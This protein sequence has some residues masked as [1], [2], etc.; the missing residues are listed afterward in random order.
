MLM[1]R[2]FPAL[3]APLNSMM[4]GLSALSKERLSSK[5]LSWAALASSPFDLFEVRMGLRSFYLKK[6]FSLTE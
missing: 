2:V 1:D 6:C 5:F 3:G 4:S